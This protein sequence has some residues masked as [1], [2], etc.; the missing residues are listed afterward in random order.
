MLNFGVA[1]WWLLRPGPSAPAPWVQ[2]A[3]VPRLQLLGEQAVAQADPVP[4]AGLEDVA[5]QPG[6]GAP[7]AEPRSRPDADAPAASNQG[8]PPLEP[9]PG[10]APQEAGS[11]SAAA[12]T[13]LRCSSY[14]P[15]ADA[16][17]VAAAR[18]ALQPLGAARTRVRDVVEAPRG[19]RVVMAPQPDRAAA[20]ALAAKIREAGF[21]DL[22]V[23]PSGDEANGIALG[24][25]GSEPSARRREA[26]LRGAGFPVQA[27][28]LGDV[29]IRHWLDVAAGPA[30]DAAAARGAAAAAQVQ[31]IDCTGIVVAGGAR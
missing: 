23:V 11:A 1:T 16:V 22:L 6:E 2:P 18:N 13:A 31:D 25:Y 29:V 10:S 21:D 30:F 9:A 14:G 20:D 17:S 27:Q 3:D 26:A 12:A 24:R 5:S 4:E 15:Y 19:W 8:A 7:A 28:P